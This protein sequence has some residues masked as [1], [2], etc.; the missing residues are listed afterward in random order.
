M[1]QSFLLFFAVVHAVFGD[2]TELPI[3][4]LQNI[5]LSDPTFSSLELPPAP[6][7]PKMKSPLLAATLSILIPGLGHVYLGEYG[8]ASKLFGASTF[9]AGVG[10]SLAQDPTSSDESHFLTI[11]SCTWSYGIYAAYRDARLH[12]GSGYYTYVMPKED[13]SDLAF[14]PVQWGVLK[15]PEVWG[16]FLGAMT[17]AAGI[18]YFA[19]S[20]APDAKVALSS[21]SSFTP[22]IAW[23]VGIGEES[24]FRGFLQSTFSESLTPLGGIALSSLLFGAAHIPNALLLPKQERNQYYAISLP[25]ITALGSYMVWMTYKNHSLQES[26]ALHVWYDFTLFAIEAAANKASTGRTDLQFSF[27]F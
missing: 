10:V 19:Y 21:S 18:S 27:S 25:F 7:L 22:L 16:G 3:P 4:T 12:N 1:K 5:E 24:L 9:S 23:P 6:E 14:A 15:K 2:L 11:S 20:N 13:F 8:T 17:L 26:T